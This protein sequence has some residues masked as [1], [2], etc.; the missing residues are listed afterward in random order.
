MIRQI[1]P[2]AILLFFT[3][4][5]LSQGSLLYHE[6]TMGTTGCG[7]TAY[8]NTLLPA[9]ADSVKLS[10]KVAA[11]LN[12]SLPRIYYTTDGSNPSGV[13]GI[14][15]GTTKVVE[16]AFRCT[17]GGY[18]IATGIIPPLPSGTIVKYIISASA[19][20][21][22]EVFGN[23]APCG[24][25]QP[26]VTST[27]ATAFTYTVQGVLPIHF[28]NFTAREGSKAIRLYWASAQEANMSRYEVYH[29]RNSLQ[30]DKLGTVTALGNSNQR[31]DYFFDDQRPLTGNNYY[32]ITAFDRGGQSVSTSIIRVLFGK[33]D[34]SVVV[35]ANPSANFINVRV[36]DIVKGDYAVRVF[37]NGGKLLVNERLNHNG[38]DAIY[39]VALPRALAKGNYR[40]VL[41]NKYQFYRSAFMIQ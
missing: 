19:G 18:S 11:S 7:G 6:R 16:A 35:F 3:M 25:C 37:D 23:S 8:A 31:T 27:Y 36:V 4:S 22:Y 29:S 1:V 38:A 14:A 21:G 10:F 41:T 5:G 9:P 2:A 32:K 39:P 17:V 28:V 15:T 20:Q 26:I 30:F 40:L 24:G 13:T 33:N 34:N 12:A